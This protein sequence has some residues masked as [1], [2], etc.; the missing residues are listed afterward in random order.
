MH[1]HAKKIRI[2]LF[3]VLLLAPMG[4]LRA[5]PSPGIVRPPAVPLMVHNSYFSVWAFSEILSQANIVNW[6]RNPNPMT[7]LVDVD[8]KVFRLMGAPKSSLPLLD[9]KSLVVDPTKT[10]FVFSN[11]EIEVQLTFFSPVLV[12]DLKLLARPVSFIAWQLRTRDSKPKRARVYFDVE[13]DIALLDAN[14]SAKFEQV[15][16]AE[17]DFLRV[18]SVE[19]HVLGYRGDVTPLDWGYC[20]LALPASERDASGFGPAAPMREA[21]VRRQFKHDAF[22]DAGPF[23]PAQQQAAMAVAIDFGSVGAEPVEKR[24]MIGYD[25]SPELQYFSRAME[26]FWKNETPSFEALLRKCW[27]EYPAVNARCA[28]FDQRL[29]GDACKVGGEPYAQLVSLLYRQVIGAHH[30]TRDEGGH[31]VYFSRENASNSSVSTVDVSFPAS[32]FFILH[33]TDLLKSMLVPILDYAKSSDWTHDSSPHSLGTFPYATGQRYGGSGSPMP[34]E[35]TGNMLMMIAAICQVEGDPGF[36]NR[37]RSLLAKWANY[38]S[39]N[40]YNTGE[41][42]CTDDFRGR[43]LNNTNLSVKGI[44]G[45]AAYA[46]VLEMQGEKEKAAG[47]AT[48]AKAWAQK[49]EKEAL[50]PDETHFV[51]A[52]GQPETW[53]FKYN[54]VWD[55]V[56]GLRLFSPETYRKEFDFYGSKLEK[57]GV[58]MDYRDKRT[59][60][61]Y[62]FWVACF[63][64]SREQ[65]DR[66]LNPIYRMVNESSTRLPLTDY[67]NTDTGT[68]AQFYARSVM[69]AVWMPLILDSATLK[70]WAA[71]SPSK[72]KEWSPPPAHPKF[73]TIISAGE[74]NWKYTVDEPSADWVQPAFSDGAWAV[75][76]LPL[77]TRM[78]SN[79]RPGETPWP[80]GRSKVWL[81]KSF[82]KPALHGGELQML[83]SYQD[84]FDVYLNGKLVFATNPGT[85]SSLPFSRIERIYPLKVSQA[86]FSEQNVIAIYCQCSRKAPY[87][88]FALEEE[89]TSKL[90]SV[91]PSA[92]EADDIQ[93]RYTTE[94]PGDGW[95]KPDFNVGAW[96]AG[97]AGFGSHGT[98][99]A[100]VRTEWTTPDIWLRREIDLPAGSNRDLQAWIYYDDDAEVYING[101]LA[102]KKRGYIVGY[103]AS[104]L[105]PGARLAFRPGKNCVAVHCHQ[106][107]GGQYIDLGFVREPTSAWSQPPTQQYIG[108][109][110]P[111]PA[112]VIKSAVPL[113]AGEFDMADVRLLD[114]PFK[115][116]METDREYLL[117]LEPDRFLAWFR[118]EAGLK[119]KAEVYGGW[120]SSGVAGHCLGHYLSACS[121][122]FRAT[123]DE[124]MRSRVALIVDELA[125]CQKANGDGYVAAIP[126]GKKA[127][128]E[129][130]AGE[131][132]PN[133]GFNLNGIWVPWYTMHKVMAGLLDAWTQCGNSR[134]REVLIALTD[135]IDGV[136]KNLDDAKMQSL[137]FVEQGGMAETLANLYALT[138][139]PRH[140]ALAQKFRH[141]AIFDPMAAGND[142]LNGW[143]G[144]AQIPKFIGYQ[145]VYELTG[146]PKWGAAARNFWTFVTRDRSFNIGGH[147]LGEHFFPL[148]KF[149]NAMTDVVGPE[150]CNTYNMLKLTRHLYSLDAKAAKMDFYERGLYNQILPSQN[151]M[152]GGLVYYTALVSSG[153]YRAY[154]DDFGCFWCCVGTGM[155]NHALYGEGIYSSK[156]DRLLVNLFIPSELN[157]REQGITVTQSTK[158]PAEPRTEFRFKTSVTATDRKLTVAVRYPGWVAPGALKLTVNGEAV[159][160]SANPGSYAEVSRQWKNGDVL[161]V[162]LPMRITT[163]FLPAS[164]NYLSIFYGPLVLGGKLG[165]EGLSDRDFVGQGM[166]AKK[167]LPVSKTPAIVV[168]PAEIAAHIEPIDGQPLAFQTKGLLKPAEL[169]LVPLYQIHEERYA[170]YW[171]LTTAETWQTDMDHVAAA[172]K[173]QRELDARSVDF[174]QPGEQQPEVDHSFKGEET[175]AG[176]HGDMHWR[177]A[178][179]GGWFSYDM[180]VSAAGPLKLLCTYWGSDSAR[181]FDILVDG[182]LVA[183]EKLT[184]KEPGKLIDVAY[185]LPDSLLAGKNK[186][187]VKFQAKPNQTAGGLFDCR[188]L[189]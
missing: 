152:T 91:V 31:P 45:L 186:V 37:Y 52:F 94:T 64:D 120:E 18:G 121:E 32:P 105:S 21:F 79:N 25:S 72:V 98:P 46:K 83:V 77:G 34:V 167:R 102:L 168:A 60:F 103:Q 87:L 88:N 95:F 23:R 76:A 131:V 183:T 116:A 63:A 154:S 153:A 176:I 104:P 49:W 188:V 179:N 124:R 71:R 96:K 125:Q 122:M 40:G 150:T 6:T 181:E 175:N 13:S 61:D 174:V 20:Y 156:G 134:A 101:V 48:Q 47:F 69:G 160:C 65:R 86:D 155:E 54:M 130:R 14:E 44:C 145:R 109:L 180:K 136:V 82:A 5:V 171:R 51:Q 100:M 118:K 80:E 9:Q 163:E 42:L 132:H 92:Q 59:K 112:P 29:K 119:P 144:N 17:F 38:L 157:W 164:K 89:V 137:L 110:P 57:Y 123:G 185:P 30:L 187:T 148:D 115:S 108:K 26:S 141:S 99:K 67:F 15:Q 93:W 7:C 27:V 85:Q 39:K 138:G 50:S 3:A 165:C 170:A 107:W 117:R 159:S 126:G 4:T 16:D 1:H 43:Q 12:E 78:G 10:I 182:T 139:E 75:A 22:H 36:A 173:A 162:E 166:S 2:L 140:L 56:L 53:S 178:R 127:F 33:S 90:I 81:R 19:Q 73:E 62:N 177:D 189:K 58:P 35:E 114:S 146:A 161:K 158:F 111:I 143:H 184:G 66:L 84:D 106:V 11:P 147:G 28:D 70:Q 74:S 97:L 41:Q 24:V 68:I 169:T 8:G 149:E 172:E 113:Q 151:P 55:K 133:G 142:I 128:S 135:W 129:M